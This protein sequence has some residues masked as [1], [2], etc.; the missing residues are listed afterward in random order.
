MTKEE[1]QAHPQAVIGSISAV[2]DYESWGSN[3][4]PVD[5]RVW[6]KVR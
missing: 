5:G 6:I 2:P 3:N 4:V 1:I